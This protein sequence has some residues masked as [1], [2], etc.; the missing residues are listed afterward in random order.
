[1]AEAFNRMARDAALRYQAL[2]QEVPDEWVESVVHRYLR[3]MPTKEEVAGVRL[4]WRPG[5]L[6]RD[7]Q[8]QEELLEITRIEAEREVVQMRMR[9]ETEEVRSRERQLALAEEMARR[10]ADEQ[11]EAK[12]RM[13]EEAMARYCEQLNEMGF[14]FR[15]AWD[16]LRARVYEDAVAIAESIKKNGYL[17]GKTAQRAIRMS[18]TFRLLNSQD[19]TEL[20]ALL[21]Q[22]ERMATAPIPKRARRRAPG[23]ITSVLEEISRL[24]HTSALEMR[25]RLEPSR[26][27]ALEV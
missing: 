10:D 26:F 16:Q 20:A 4:I 21:E 6:V 5:M 11:M 1:M 12:R 3:A 17:R 15:E 7:S 27:K 9:L 13:R 22:L 23:P 19:D 25:R 2:G 14:P 18:R 24:T 8:I